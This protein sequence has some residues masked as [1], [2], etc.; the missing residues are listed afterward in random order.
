MIDFQVHPQLVLYAEE[1]G[2]GPFEEGFGEVEQVKF[3]DRLY[4]GGTRIV[5]RRA[6]DERHPHQELAVLLEDAVDLA[7]RFVQEQHVVER[8]RRDRH[9]EAAI[10]PGQEFR[11]SLIETERMFRGVRNRVD[12]ENVVGWIL[13]QV[14]RDRLR[15]AADI[16]HITT[17][18]LI[19]EIGEQRSRRV[20][21]H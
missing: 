8:G 9:V 19:D 2:Q 20:T 5:R 7:E 12:S 6:G 4:V 11:N 16:Q 17:K 1:S 3:V 15:T 21:I 18:E 13:L 10:V 14:Q